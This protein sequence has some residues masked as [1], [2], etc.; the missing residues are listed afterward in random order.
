M[1]VDDRE[2][3][4]FAQEKVAVESTDRDIRDADV[5]GLAPAHFDQSHIV[6]VTHMQG[7][8]DRVTD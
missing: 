5:G 3:A 8:V 4:I 2:C 7:L 6:E 1:V